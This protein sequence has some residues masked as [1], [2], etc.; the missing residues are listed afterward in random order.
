MAAIQGQHT[1]ASKFE[2]T[3]VFK[4]N[5]SKHIITESSCD[6]CRRYGADKSINMQGFNVTRF[7]AIFSSR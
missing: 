4:D 7:R 1:F 6:I 3:L 5:L 2:L